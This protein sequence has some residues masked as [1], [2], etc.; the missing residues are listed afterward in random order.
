MA[1]QIVDTD[2]VTI[3]DIKSL[4]TTDDLYVKAGVL[5]GST[6][7]STCVT[8]T[9]VGQ[10]VHIEGQLVSDFRCLELG[11]DSAAAGNETYLGASSIL[12]SFG[13]AAVLLRGGG[14]MFEAHGKI[15]A[16]IYAIAMQAGT[17]S[18][19]AL[20]NTGLLSA[21]DTGVFVD[22]SDVVTIEN[23]GV[24]AGDLDGIWIQGSSGGV[25]I[26]NSGTIKGAQ[27]VVNVSTGSLTIENSG[28]I[29]RGAELGGQSD[30]YDG[31]TG[32]ITGTLK[33][34]AGDDTIKGG[35][36]DESFE[37]DAGKDLLTGGKGAD[38]FIYVDAG[39]STLGATGRDLITDFSRKNH[40]VVDFSTLIEGELDFVGKAQ[41]SGENEVR[42]KISGGSTFVYVNLDSDSTAE[43]AIQFTGRIKFVE[44]DFAL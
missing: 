20:T 43:M 4:G 13:E 39:D 6:S 5:L 18:D 1:L 11:T 22:T 28:L 3:G 36:Y 7:A 16:Q 34:R 41:F 40:D 25:T 2:I 32:R 37:G 38:M 26:I 23:S 29:R 15:F 24:I 12:R 9:G 31:T 10:V 30:S 8:S 17:G 21:Q 44:A 27:G 19:S 14:H 33:A 42:Y 35:V